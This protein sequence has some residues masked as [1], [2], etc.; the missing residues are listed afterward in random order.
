M[1]MHTCEWKHVHLY[2]CVHM[3]T[4]MYV[5]PCKRVNITYT[6]MYLHRNPSIQICIN[7]HKQKFQLRKFGF[8]RFFESGF[9]EPSFGDDLILLVTES[10]LKFH[11]TS[12]EID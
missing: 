5:C 6:Y 7:Q 11:L 12:L 4:C 3:Y 9:G 10:T 2:V 1:R 8:V